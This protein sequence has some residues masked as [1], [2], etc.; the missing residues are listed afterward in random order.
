MNRFNPDKY[1][2]CEDAVARL[3]AKAPMF[4]EA[5]KRH[6]DYQQW[7]PVDFNHSRDYGSGRPDGPRRLARVK[8]YLERRNVGGI[9]CL[10]RTDFGVLYMLVGA[11]S[12][13][14]AFGPCSFG[15]RGD[16]T[17]ERMRCTVST[18]ADINR[19]IEP[20]TKS[21]DL[22]SRNFND[23]SALQKATGFDTNV[24]QALAVED[25]NSLCNL[26][27]SAMGGH[28]KMT[29]LVKGMMLYLDLLHY[30]PQGFAHQINN[31]MQYQ[32]GQVVASFRARERSHSFCSK[33]STH[34]VSVM[35]LIGLEYP[36]NVGGLVCRGSSNIP[37]DANEHYV[38]VR[39]NAAPGMYQCRLSANSVWT[40][41]WHTRGRWITETHWKRHY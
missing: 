28:N 27:R 11:V 36:F 16:I 25:V 40:S 21:H 18:Y 34:Y 37:A 9:D 20:T 33:S 41:L 3:R 4:Q 10:R 15:L 14:S 23:R 8:E 12:N 35:Y 6:R 5:V 7:S 26:L 24:V 1:R 31:V 13:K 2:R 39:G 38:V 19:K 22:L 30:G 17:W 32:A 29:R